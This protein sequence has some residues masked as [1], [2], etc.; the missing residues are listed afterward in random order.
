MSLRSKKKEILSNFVDSKLIN[1]LSN[2][3]LF[4]RNS[5]LF[6]IDLLNGIDE[7]KYKLMHKK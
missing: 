6:N 7:K 5:K 1:D 3:F 4:N 2:I